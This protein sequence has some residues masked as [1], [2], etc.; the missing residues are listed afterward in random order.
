M[1]PVL[2]LWLPILLSA[3]VVFLLSSLLHM[4]LS[5][6]NNDYLGLPNEQAV[7]D[8]LRPF[9]IPPGDYMF[10]HAHGM[11]EAGTAEFKEKWARG[12]VGLMTVVRSKAPGMG[13]EL[14]QWFVYCIV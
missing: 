11:K 2:S 4:V 8:A 12:P 9:N 1:V 3:V 7:L 14:V 13:K 6:H 10:P 5:Y